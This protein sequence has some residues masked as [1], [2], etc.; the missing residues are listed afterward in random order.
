VFGWLLHAVLGFVDRYGYVAVFVYM[1]LETSFILHF[2]PSEVVVPFAASQLVHGPASFVLFVLDATAGSTVGSLVAY[3]LF[4]G[5]GRDLLDRYGHLIHVSERDLDRSEAVFVRYGESSVFWGRLL[6]F[7]RALISIPAGM[8]EMDLTKF[9]VYS[10]AGALLFNTGLTYLVYTGRGGT[11]PL[12]LV[13][14]R[15]LRAATDEVRYARGHP[16]FVAALV[17]AAAVFV[18][19]CAVV[20]L[21]R[22]RLREDPHL[23]ARLVLHL[24]RLVGVLV[25]AAFVAGAL[26]SPSSAFGVVTTLWDDP[27]FFVHLGFSDRLA[28]ALLGALVALA[29]IFV[30]EVGRLVEAT[31]LDEAVQVARERLDR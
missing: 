20:W 25:G 4:G 31:W 27:L 18:V 12:G 28:L 15:F 24:V 29:G 6:P 23:A 22:D 9:V 30:Y 21:E 1:A 3:W 26:Y 7:L 2:V 16:A 17:A 5:Y 11:S 10:S 14:G 8:V 19:L 13:A